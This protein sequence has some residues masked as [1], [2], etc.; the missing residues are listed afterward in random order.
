ML[1]SY[2]ITQC[3]PFTY[4]GLLYRWPIFCFQVIPLRLWENLLSVG[5]QLSSSLLIKG[6]AWFSPIL[7]TCS[8]PQTLPPFP[9]VSS[10]Q[11]A[12]LQ[13]SFGG[14]GHRREQV[15]KL[16]TTDGNPSIRFSR[17]LGVRVEL[18]LQ[19]ECFRR[20]LTQPRSKQ[21]NRIPPQPFT[22]VTEVSGKRKDL[23]KWMAFIRLLD[24]LDNSLVYPKADGHRQKAQGNVSN[25]THNT[26]YR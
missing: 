18:H 14:A 8:Q 11:E 10:L 9:G 16:H 6:G 3:S 24:C 2:T 15:E 19:G 26:E 20:W 4:K 25:H 23:P 21:K 12:E 5:S 17:D 7:S 13:K 1:L 22:S